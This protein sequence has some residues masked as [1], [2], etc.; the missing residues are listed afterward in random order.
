MGEAL[1]PSFDGMTAESLAIAVESY[2]AIDA[3]CSTP[4]MTE[5]SLERL[6]EIMRNAGELDGDPSFENVVDNSLA[7]EIVGEG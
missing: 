6:K 2:L 7:E 3:W 5:E 1:E 4:V